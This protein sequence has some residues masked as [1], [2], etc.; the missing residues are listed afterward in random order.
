MERDEAEK[1]VEL[2]REAVAGAKQRT[3]L[4]T[5]D[6]ADAEEELIARLEDLDVPEPWR[7]AEPLAAAG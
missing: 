3:P 1:L 4:D 6:V 2:Q 5:L 7:V